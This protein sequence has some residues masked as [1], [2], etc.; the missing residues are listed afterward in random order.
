MPHFGFPEPQLMTAHTVPV[1]TIGSRYSVIEDTNFGSRLGWWE[2][3]YYRA[4]GT[5]NEGEIVAEYQLTITDV[6]GGSTTTCTEAAGFPATANL[7]IGGIFHVDDDAGGAGAA[8]EG[9]SC[10]ITESAAGSI[11]FTPALTAALA[12]NDD[13]SIHHPYLGVQGAATSGNAVIGLCL[14]TVAVGEYGFALRRGLYPNAEFVTADAIAIG[15]GVQC[16]AN[17]Q[18]IEYDVAT[19]TLNS[20][21]GHVMGARL[22]GEAPTNFPVM[23]TLP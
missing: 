17:G 4:T 1:A 13:V 9:E 2:V 12:A 6:D 19:H 3:I 8:P 7:L 20:P 21:I 18:F 16:A 15:A 11:T 10:I 22:V 5:I 23:M 14:A